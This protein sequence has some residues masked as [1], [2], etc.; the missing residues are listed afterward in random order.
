[1]DSDDNKAT[2]SENGSDNSYVQVSSED[3]QLHMEPGSQLPLHDSPQLLSGSG[4]TEEGD[5]P[6]GE[7][8]NTITTPPETVQVMFWCRHFGILAVTT[9]ANLIPD[10]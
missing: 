6:F 10:L 8:D 1:M 2:E 9:H 4:M 5:F 7:G 3:A